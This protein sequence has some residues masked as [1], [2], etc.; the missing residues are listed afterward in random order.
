MQFYTTFKVVHMYDDCT[1]IHKEICL[2]KHQVQHLEI[3]KGILDENSFAFDLSDMGTGKTYV[4]ASLC[5]QGTYEHVV[6]VCPVSVKSKWYS[7]QSTYRGLHIDN[8]LSFCELRS[9][10]FKQPKHKLL[11][12]TDTTRRLRTL[13]GFTEVKKTE[14][15]CT[16]QFEDMVEH[17]LL[18]I[19]DEFQNIKN[20]N[21]QLRA[22]KAFMSCIN[23]DTRS[24]A[25]FL[26]GSPID[27][28]EQAA[29]MC[30]V[31]QIMKHSHL[32]VF[33]PMT[34]TKNPKG[35][36]DI[37]QFCVSRFGADEVMCIENAISGIRNS[38]TFMHEYA[39]ALLLLIMRKYGHAMHLPDSLSDTVLVQQNAFYTLNDK[40]KMRLVQNGIELLSK[41]TMF[42]TRTESLVAGGG[43]ESLR[44][45]TRALTMIETGKLPIF[46]RI[47]KSH[48]EQKRKV[49][50]C[51]NY[52]SS[53]T[54]LKYA[55]S[56]Y[57]PLVIDGSTSYTKRGDVIEKFQ[58]DSF[59]YPLL[60]GNLEV[61]STGI[62]L[63]DKHGTFPRTCLVNANYR[64]ITLY[65]LGSRFKRSDTQSN[66]LVQFVFADLP[67]TELRILN[68]LAKKSSVMKSVRSTGSNL[69]YPGD[70]EHWYESNTSKPLNQDSG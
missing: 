3:I 25:L 68:A 36:N 27:K 63:D 37:V 65:Q 33:N 7:M 60:V 2:F 6:V 42:N 50:I 8:V 48:I 49:V 52:A 15:R 66:A 18:L 67:K 4:S 12:R 45:I 43:M 24:K 1:M 44:G 30:R 69:T 9:V 54:D 55:L 38:E 34:Y 40:A 59:E 22:I 35:L 61:C 13:N 41:T 56:E 53:I 23:R 31:L 10:R 17:G 5:Q 57:N 11:V 26:S 29:H 32:C 39:H 62:D 64:T 16:T 14:F 47:A 58:R 21:S 70:Y 20:M 51:V 28:I 46:V 19:V